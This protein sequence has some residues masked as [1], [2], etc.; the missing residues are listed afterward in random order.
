[1]NSEKRKERAKRKARRSPAAKSQL[2]YEQ[3]LDRNEIRRSHGYPIK[4]MKPHYE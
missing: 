4:W 1:M 3:R 2:T